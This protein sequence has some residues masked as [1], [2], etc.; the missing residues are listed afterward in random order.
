M[1]NGLS[2][3]QFFKYS[4]IMTSIAVAIPRTLLAKSTAMTEP[5]VIF[6]NPIGFN[7]Q[8]KDFAADMYHLGNGYRVYNPALGSFHQFDGEMAPFG[9]AGI[10]G[11]TFGANDPIN[12]IDPSGRLD[13][14]GIVGSIL[15]LLFSVA[16][17]AATIIS[18]GLAAI[19]SLALSLTTLTA[20][21]VSGSTGIAAAI[22]DDPSHPAYNTLSTA[23]SVSGLVIDVASVGLG[24]IGVVKHGT[25]VAG[26]SASLL[27][28][29]RKAKWL[30]KA[31]LSLESL[32]MVGTSLGVAS[33]F[34]GNETLGKVGLGLN[35]GSNALKLGFYSRMPVKTVKSNL[36]K[37]KDGD[38]NKRP[39]LAR[40]NSN[41][42][43]SNGP[44]LGSYTQ[45]QMAASKIVKETIRSARVARNTY[46]MAHNSSPSPAVEMAQSGSFSVLSDTRN[47]LREDFIGSLDAIT[48]RHQHFK[49]PDTEEYGFGL[50]HLNA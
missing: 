14:S 50:G 40:Q 42:G 41:L 3:R 13:V 33:S 2:R 4:A 38:L 48:E 44:S 47:G 30:T 27:K 8:P 7:G 46:R 21:L 37:P 45:G 25:K 17:A 5:A 26:K 12:N 29:I 18:G 31:E 19:P 16:V 9:D 39:P 24:G 32:D 6:E 36:T 34:N 22:I 11:Y 35:I 1:S 49:G 20:G 43:S 28:K 23:S 10:N 15:G